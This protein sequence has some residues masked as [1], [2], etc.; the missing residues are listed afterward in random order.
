ML[1]V[2]IQIHNFSI[3]TV[4]YSLP[5]I[6]RNTRYITKIVE[7]NTVIPIWIVIGDYKNIE[8]V[9]NIISITVE[10]S[11]VWFRVLEFQGLK[12]NKLI[13]YMN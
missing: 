2:G 12:L 6:C 4:I 5:A 3:P 11:R 8:L 13:I 10:M 7:D 1:H 9:W